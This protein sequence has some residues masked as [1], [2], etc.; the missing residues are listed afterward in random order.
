MPATKWVTRPAVWRQISG[1]VVCSWDLPHQAFGGRVV[2][3]RVGRLDRHRADHHLGP[4][5]P[6]QVD[7]LGRHLVGD[8]EDAVVAPLRG[9]DGEPDAR[10]ARRRLDDGAARLQQAVPFG[11]VDH[12][13]GGPVLHAAARVRGLELGDHLARQM[14]GDPAQPHERRVADQVE[15]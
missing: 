14:A 1:P 9:H 2:A 12:G 7:L 5:R 6:Q 10:V 13:D 4:V 3:G 8:D 15:G 11:G